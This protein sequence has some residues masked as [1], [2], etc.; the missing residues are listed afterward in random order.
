MKPISRASGRSAVASA[1]YR[2]G[3]VLTNERDGITHDF[4]RRDGVEHSEIVLPEGVSAEW[5]LDRSALWNAAERAE[6]RKDAR[7]AREFEIALPHELSQDQRLETARAF[8]RDLA[9]RYGAAVDFAI[10]APHEPSDVRNHH[11]HV[12]MTT[13]KVAAEGLGDKT[14]IER[15][16]KWLIANDLPTTDV[17]LR[18]IRGAWEQIA[19]ERLALAGL[20]VRI[21]HR[22]HGERGLEIEPTEHMGVHATQMLRRG[23]EVARIRLDTE[24]ARRNAELIR[25]KPDQVLSLITNERSVFDRRDIAGALHRYINDDAQAFQNALASVM[26]SPALVTLQPERTG[27]ETGEVS[28][29][30]YSTREMVEV[31]GGMARAAERMEAARTHGVDRRHVE[32]AIGRQDAALARGEPGRRARLSDE[33]RAAI[34][35]ITGPA[36]IAAVV[37]FAGAGKSTML[38]AARE[39]WEA[40]GYRVH[41]AA[42]SGKAAEGLEESSGIQSRTL[43]SWDM[44]WRNDRR[45]LGSGDVLVVDEAGMVGSRQLARFVGEA[46]SRGAKIVVVGDHEQLQAIGAGAP[47]RAIAE[48]VGH[49]ELSEIR[50][51]RVDWQ[52]QASIAF[53]SHRTGE[54]LS[55]YRAHGAVRME[56]DGA[57]ARAAIVRD[58]LADRDARPD[59]TRVASAHRRAD[60]RA[61]NDAIRL[62]LQDSGALARGE[63]SGEILFRTT[64]GPRLFAP[65]DRIVF[66]ENDRELGVKNGMLGT[67]EAVEPHAIQVRL[68]GKAG[69]EA[70]RKVTVTPETYQALDHGYATTI[71]KTQGATVD[72]AFVLASETMDRHLTYVAMTRHRDGVQLYASQAEFAGHNAGRLIEHG[73]APYNNDPR[74]GASYFVTLEGNGGQ[75]RTLWGV[76]LERALAEARPSIGDMIVLEA[77]GSETVRLP[78]GGTTGERQ[79]WK[80]SSAGD[81]A[82]RRL[83]S[84]LSRSGLKETTL[85]Y[86]LDFAERRGIAETLGVRS[87]IEIRARQAS[88]AGPAEAAAGGDHPARAPEASEA[89][90]GGLAADR[91]DPITSDPFPQVGAEAADGEALAKALAWADKAADAAL[92]RLEQQE[93]KAR[94]QAERAAREAQRK[95]EQE[96]EQEPPRPR[97][98]FGPGM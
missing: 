69:P 79:E 89:G 70:L 44:G 63:A 94:E 41:G 9:D 3:E 53:A 19:N 80:V 49:A 68:D 42:L 71:H 16:N 22:S 51:Q 77:A 57:A 75:R 78:G 38:L 17:Q 37:G 83:E 45:V 84:R 21:D 20:D 1:A 56:A 72:R 11:A 7:V 14:Y 8:A 52:R 64:N 33:Q 87:E 10:H 95:I 58:Y 34:A 61:I 48:Q 43:A 12:M 25:E 29:A 13:R 15:E 28:A 40:Q 92:A 32:A 55:A 6:K 76:G 97:P 18:D 67:I 39:A 82:W 96:R 4:T 2:A 66:L 86:A 73:R 85:D 35:H 81:A 59:G 26:A 60:V 91:L 90:R 27:P 50:R 5:A 54:G 88:T 36:R 30:R 62:A 74:N 47:F 31:E 46:E 93:Q 23:M 98:R 65:G 24:A